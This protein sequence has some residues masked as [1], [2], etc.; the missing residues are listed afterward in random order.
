MVQV[1]V[2]V[3]QG[4]QSVPLLDLLLDLAIGPKRELMN[5][6][7]LAKDTSQTCTTQASFQVYHDSG[8]SATSREDI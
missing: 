5:I 2:L 6:S 7:P 1:Q 4:R 8:G 3:F